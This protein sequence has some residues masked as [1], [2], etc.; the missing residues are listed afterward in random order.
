MLSNENNMDKNQIKFNSNGKLLSGIAGD[1]SGESITPVGYIK[2]KNLHKLNLKCCPLFPKEKL[3][4]SKTVFYKK[5]KDDEQNK[6]LIHPKY[7]YNKE[8]QEALNSIQKRCWYN[9]CTD[10]SVCALELA[11]EI[12]EDPNGNINPGS[13]TARLIN[14]TNKNPNLLKKFGGGVK[15]LLKEINGEQNKEINLKD[16]QAIISINDRLKQIKKTSR[17][18]QECLG[19][20]D[21]NGGP[22]RIC[23]VGLAAKN[24]ADL[25]NKVEKAV[26]NTH[27]SKGGFRSALA[28][29]TFIYLSRIGWNQENI[30][31]YINIKFRNKNISANRGPHSKEYYDY[32]MDNL[33]LDTLRK[34]FVRSNLGDDTAV[35]ALRIVLQAGSFLEASSMA[36][37]F[38]GDSDTL[39]SIIDAMM[40]V[41]AGIPI[42][43]QN[44][45][46]DLLKNDPSS[47]V[48]KYIDTS[49]QFDKKYGGYYRENAPL[50]WQ[51]EQTLEVIQSLKNK[52]EEINNPEEKMEKQKLLNSLIESV[53]T[54]WRHV[55]DKEYKYEAKQIDTPKENGFTGEL[56]TNAFGL[57]WENRMW[58][59]VLFFVFLPIISVALPIILFKL[60]FFQIALLF[61]GVL[62]VDFLICFWRI[63]AFYKDKKQAALI[64]W[65][66]TY[67][68][69]EKKYCET[70]NQHNQAT[71]EYQTKIKND[72][73]NKFK[74]REMEEL[75]TKVK[76]LENYLSTNIEGIKD[77]LLSDPN[78]EL[79]YKGMSE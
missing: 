21:A 62:V 26:E 11:N 15:K 53:K 76:T 60:L 61:F 75:K 48:Q 50:D 69:V 30:K 8:A 4:K 29:A 78:T 55:L 9:H 41:H 33:D 42:E 54:N 52:I 74:V 23:A 56:H 14:F 36:K 19:L 18:K 17:S 16:Q 2:D 71:A 66:D 43:Y 44:E 64:Y 59:F 25:E 45:M 34:N 27:D 51:L 31:I 46:K 57:Y 68:P 58:R 5:D 40:G 13:Y 24:L 49:N 39:E 1:Y 37:S 47:E 10:D 63:N 12:L 73:L 22:M 3:F 28:V 38:G 67:Y 7:L 70:I 32:D 77:K 72:K 35:L 65:R 79:V 6:L 20:S